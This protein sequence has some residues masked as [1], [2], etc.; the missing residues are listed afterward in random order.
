MKA[1]IRTTL[2]SD[3]GVTFRAYPV[4]LYATMTDAIIIKTPLIK[5]LNL[6]RSQNSEKK[7]NRTNSKTSKLLQKPT[8]IN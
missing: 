6:L 8:K 4:I 3:T 2:G 1:K 5:A 7:Q